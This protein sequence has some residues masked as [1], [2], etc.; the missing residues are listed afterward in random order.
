MLFARW[1][2]KERGA[3]VEIWGVAHGGKLTARC[4]ESGIPWRVIGNPFVGGF[5]KT[6]W[7]LLKIAWCLRKARVDVILPYTLVPNVIAGFVWRLTGASLSVWNQRDEGTEGH[8]EPFEHWAVRLTPLFLANSIAGADYVIHTLL[9]DKNKV[10]VVHNGIALDS[11]TEDRLVWRQRLKL[12]DTAVCVAMV[13]NLSTKKDHATLINAW[14]HLVESLSPLLGELKLVLAGRFDDAAQELIE[15]VKS[16]CLEEY[17]VLCG[18]VHDV[19]GFLQAVDIGVYSSTS[20]GLPNGVI[21]CMVT[22]KAI[23]ATN[24]PG[25]REALGDDYT[26]LSKPGDHEGMAAHL[27]TLIHNHELRR[28]VGW[29]NRERALACFDTETM[30]RKMAGILD[31]NLAVNYR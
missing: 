21:E 9:A 28:K 20:E 16:F 7:H 5:V 10:S 19:A 23:A 13:A 8:R 27:M 30:C 15:L 22:G 18:P 2:K 4:E 3:D 14:K 25:I 1:L 26:F 29:Q 6:L 31:A 24:I 11:P 12:S 17:V